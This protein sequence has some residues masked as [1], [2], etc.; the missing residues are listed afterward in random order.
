MSDLKDDWLDYEGLADLAAEEQLTAAPEGAE[1]RV[2]GRLMAAVGAPLSGGLD[3]LDAGQTATQTADLV[4]GAGELASAS[5]PHTASVG[6]VVATGSAIG[7][8][9]TIGTSALGAKGLALLLTIAGGGAAITMG[10]GQ[11]ETTV[12]PPAITVV[13]SK[14]SPTAAV[15]VNEIEATARPTGSE[16][17][18]AIENDLRPTAA[19][20]TRLVP[21]VA[22]TP[23]N[24]L[25]PARSGRAKRPV[26]VASK[27]SSI[28]EDAAPS[29][30]SRAAGKAPSVGRATAVT[31]RRDDALLAE[32]TLL[33]GA[34]RDI[35]KRDFAGALISV[36]HHEISHP[37]GRLTEERELLRIQALVLAGR[38]GEAERAADRFRRRFPQSLMLQALEYA[39]N[40]DAGVR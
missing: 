14:A 37:K 17:R 30:P 28:I 11:E 23:E 18:P 36:R 8:G 19:E 31:P 7:G 4:H 22:P 3:A 26:V 6:S 13:N 38:L 27:S 16:T 1:D 2:Y 35:A 25:E 39:L 40:P 9:A 33:R 32:Q 10:V 12:E 15:E 21:A 29:R 5:L 20:S 34:R 24:R